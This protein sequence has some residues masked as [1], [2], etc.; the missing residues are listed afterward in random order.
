MGWPSKFFGDLDPGHPSRYAND[1][2][3]CLYG[4]STIL[5]KEIPG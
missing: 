2:H 1:E 3:E 4:S 5:F